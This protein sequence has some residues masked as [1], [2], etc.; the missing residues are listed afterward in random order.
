[1]VDVTETTVVE[2][3]PTVSLSRLKSEKTNAQHEAKRYIVIELGG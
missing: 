1:M 2:V 3:S